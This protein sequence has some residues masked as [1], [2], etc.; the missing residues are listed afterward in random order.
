MFP[1]YGQRFNE[2]SEWLYHYDLAE[3]G[4]ERNMLMISRPLWMNT[5]EFLEWEERKD[6]WDEEE[7][8]LYEARENYQ[9]ERFKNSQPYCPLCRA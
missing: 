1:D 8:M 5:N 9:D 7:D 2:Y 6:L 4:E 3:D